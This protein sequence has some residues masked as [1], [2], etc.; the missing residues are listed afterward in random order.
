MFLCLLFLHLSLG[1]R[2]S[3]LARGCQSYALFRHAALA[4]RGIAM[5][6]A[7]AEHRT[8]GCGRETPLLGAG[9]DVI[10]IYVITLVHRKQKSHTT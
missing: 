3:R 2:N 1:S 6:N 5:H 9:K 8:I 4:Q 10:L 7:C